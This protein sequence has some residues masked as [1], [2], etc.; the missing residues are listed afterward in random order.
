M[1]SPP[2][3]PSRRVIHVLR[4]DVEETVHNL[5]AEKSEEVDKILSKLLK[6]EGEVPATALTTIGQT[7]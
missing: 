6:N 3:P 7:I 2:P 5:K 1:A 4:E